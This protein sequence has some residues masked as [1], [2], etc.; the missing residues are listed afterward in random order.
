[1]GRALPTRSR[2]GGRGPRHGERG[3]FLSDKRASRPR[4]EW[5]HIRRDGHVAGHHRT[6]TRRER[7][8]GK[9]DTISSAL[10]ERKRYYLRPRSRGKL[11]FDQ[12]R[13]AAYPRLLA[14]G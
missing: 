7:S 11:P 4:R 12:R 8:E 9:R 3:W 2:W 10:R 13:R 6:Q 14:G 1:M 5:R